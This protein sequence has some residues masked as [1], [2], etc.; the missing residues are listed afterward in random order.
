MN[1]RSR[2]TA[3]CFSH[4]FSR[5][6]NILSRTRTADIH[7]SIIN[8]RKIQKINSIN[9]NITDESESKTKYEEKF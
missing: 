1:R 6:F 9:I 3:H 8:K 5:K 2:T 4:R 7:I